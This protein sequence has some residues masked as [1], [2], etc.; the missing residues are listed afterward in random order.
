M[1]P[2]ERCVDQP[3]N[4]EYVDQETGGTIG[5]ACVMSKVFWLT[6][7]TG[8]IWLVTIGFTVWVVWPTVYPVQPVQSA[9]PS[10]RGVVLERQPLTRDQEAV[11]QHVLAEA[12]GARFE[13]WFPAMRVKTSDKNAFRA[14]AEDAAV[15][16]RIGQLATASMDRR[17]P[18]MPREKDY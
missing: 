2:G 12:V 4:H 11:R 16:A 1:E 7:A 13:Q 9:V 6:V 15:G 3:A 17:R 10:E 18:D 8:M 5:E 14:Y